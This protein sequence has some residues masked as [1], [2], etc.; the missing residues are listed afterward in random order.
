MNTR[1]A[2]RAQP[3]LEVSFECVPA[4]ADVLAE[5]LPQAGALAVTMVDAGDHALLEPAPGETPLWPSTRVT[6][7]FAAETDG[8]AVLEQ[9]RAR[10][11]PAALPPARLAA[12]DDRPWELEWRKHFAPRCIDGRLW[13]VPS[14]AEPPPRAAGQAVMTLDPGVAFGTGSHPSTSLCL[15]W[16]TGL[17]L[18]GRTVVDYGCGSG[19]LAIAAVRLGAARAL[20]VDLDAQARAATDENAAR[21]GVADRVQTHAP[22]DLPA[23]DA[24]VLVANILARPLIELAPVLAALLRPGGVLALGGLL[25]GQAEAVARAY[26]P[27]CELA[28]PRRDQ[29][30]ILLTGARRPAD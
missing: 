14:W 7:L 19:I 18:A 2:T 3:L 13:I 8:G 28:A 23:G 26:A 16:L 5:L 27:W 17:D 6:G 11:A 4:T 25:A 10:L 12:L 9:L 15:G 1:T 20:A 21:N 22:G 24:D 30:W 29:E